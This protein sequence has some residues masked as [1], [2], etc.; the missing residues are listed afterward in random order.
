MID[1]TWQVRKCGSLASTYVL[2]TKG[3]A[4]LGGI[5][6]S[7][8]G[9]NPSFSAFDTASATPTLNPL[10]TSTIPTALGINNLLGMACGTGLVVKTASLT[11]AILWRPSNSGV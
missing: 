1:N 5:W 2:A 3:G 7:K 6:I 8:K 11:G 10:V 4:V 9:T